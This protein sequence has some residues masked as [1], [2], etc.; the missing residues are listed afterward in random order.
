MSTAQR[1]FKNTLILTL[2]NAIQPVISFYLIVTIS[3]VLKVEGFGEYNTILKYVAIF[4]IIAAFGLR[5]LLTREI[6]QNKTAA[7]RYL[8]AGSSIA[9]AFGLASAALMSVLAIVVSDDPFVIR[10]TIYASL[11]LVAAA[12]AEAYE[13]VISGFEK[14]SHI[15]YA[16]VL[17][18]FVRVG[19]SLAVV[20]NGYGVMALIGVYVITRYLK[21]IYYWIY[22]NKHIARPFGAIHWPFIKEL[23]MQARIFALITVCVI[24]YWNVDGIMLEAIRSKEEVGY[25]AAAYRFLLLSLVLVDSFVNSLFPVMSSFFKSSEA[26]FEMACRKSLRMLGLVTL[27]VAIA[28]SLLA[29]KIILLFYGAP[30]L[31]SARV[32]QVLIWALIPY[33]ISQIFAY[34][35]VASNNQRID[36]IVNAVSMVLNFLLNLL[37]ISRFGFMGATVAA[38]ISIAIYV[39]LQMPFVFR[40]LIK[41][42]F[43]EMLG[44]FV[45]IA[46]SALAMSTFIFLLRDV[47][48]LAVLPLSFL[49]YAMSAYLFGVISENDQALIFRLIKK[50]A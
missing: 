4:Q 42:E 24:I 18:N 20:Y 32:L 12:L 49:V 15:G 1:L 33:G 14:L 35:L 31:A 37:L 28:L 50:T 23:L 39:G 36:L 40:R 29:E 9:V 43:K 2:A 5:N 8:A 11:S 10:G 30:Y 34:A 22:I 46:L 45:R 48:V 19:L 25:Y 27:P 7:P 13:G 38:L 21:P 44:G 6:A 16:S 41:F 3:R 17:E 26:S 47:N